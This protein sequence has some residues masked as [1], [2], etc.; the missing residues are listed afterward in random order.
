[1]GRAWLVFAAAVI[2]GGLAAAQPALADD[3]DL[4]AGSGYGSD[5][6]TFER[7]CSEIQKYPAQRCAARSAEDQ[8]SF[9]DT[10]L[11]LQ[12]IEVKHAQDQRKDREF[13]DEFEAHR[14]LTPL[15]K[16]PERL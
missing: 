16:L 3:D 2:V 12:A 5:N 11:R 4:A 8:A 1:M 15:P 7:W 6:L 10:Q 13:R 14:T 9:K